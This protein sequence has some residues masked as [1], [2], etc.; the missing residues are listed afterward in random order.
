MTLHHWYDFEGGPTNSDG[1]IVQAS[2]DGENW[3]TLVPVGGS[4]YITGIDSTYPPVNGAEGG[5]S[6]NATEAGEWTDSVFDLSV[7]AGGTTLQIRF[8]MGADGGVQE[9]GWYIDR[10]DILG[11]GDP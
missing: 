2:T 4:L 1:G 8:V 10:V 3:I 5:F 7:Y 6:G 11:S 9:A